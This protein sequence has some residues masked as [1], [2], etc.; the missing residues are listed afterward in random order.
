MMISITAGL[1]KSM[2]DL[3]SPTTY[4]NYVASGGVKESL[5]E[6]LEPKSEGLGG[7]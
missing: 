1:I 5:V 3:V 4:S 6:E 7:T 2:A